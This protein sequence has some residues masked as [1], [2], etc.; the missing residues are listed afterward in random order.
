[1][2]LDPSILER[3]RLKLRYKVSYHLGSSCPDVNDI[4]QETIARFLQALKGHKMRSPE[5]TAAF[6]SG[7]C[8]NVIYEYRR[9]QR[10]EPMSEMG[11]ELHENPVAPGAD[12]VELRQVISTVMVQLAPRDGD[13]VRAFYLEQ[14]EKEEI[15]A[16]MGLTAAQFRVCLFRAK[17][18]FREI[19]RQSLKR[20]A[21]KQ[22]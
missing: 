20:N 4:V 6:L 18:K 19:F 10:R 2:T 8:N 22:H 12:V 13:I 15:C 5:S 9:R 17:H 21:A 16:T 14:R 1:V 11:D 3:Y 7:I